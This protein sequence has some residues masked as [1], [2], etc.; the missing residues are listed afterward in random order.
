MEH[1]NIVVYK[2]AEADI[3]GIIN[4][5]ST[6]LLETKTA[7]NTVQRF[8]EAI[9]SLSNTLERYALLSGKHLASLGIRMCSSGNYLFFTVDKTGHQVNILRVLYGRRSWTQ[10]LKQ[11]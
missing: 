5:I 9:L 11:F 1:Y 3:Q 8:R 2:T 6:E 10:F 7:Y 4:Y